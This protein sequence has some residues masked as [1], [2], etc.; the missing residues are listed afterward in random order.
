MIV[1]LMGY[2]TASVIGSILVSAFYSLSDTKTPTR[3]GLLGFFFSILIKSVG[4]MAYS[5]PGL[6][7]ATSL[8]YVFNALILFYKIEKKLK[9]ELSV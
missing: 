3:I 4:Y 2:V 7:F 9:N 5:L 6:V 1:L 8:Y